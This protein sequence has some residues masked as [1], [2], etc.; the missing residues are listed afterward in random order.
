MQEKPRLTGTVTRFNEMLLTA[1]LIAYRKL[2]PAS[3]SS[4]RRLRCFDAYAPRH[5]SQVPPNVENRA[6]IAVR[7]YGKGKAVRTVLFES[8]SSKLSEK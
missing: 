3:T 4:P 6:C 8:V 5:R 7:V 2:K 1:M